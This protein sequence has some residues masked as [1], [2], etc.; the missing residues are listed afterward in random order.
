MV[1]AA[2]TGTRAGAGVRVGAA[3]AGGSG[4]A[5]AGDSA[6]ARA[7]AT[8]AAGPDTALAMLL[9]CLLTAQTSCLGASL[10]APEYTHPAAAGYRTLSFRHSPVL[11]ATCR[12]C[13]VCD[14]ASEDPGSLW[15]GT[16]AIWSTEGGCGSCCRCYDVTRA[17]T[18]T[19]ARLPSRPR[20]YPP[21]HPG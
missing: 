2:G 7:H 18:M 21:V 13:P 8:A 17:H 5:P 11:V 12:S 19:L 4:G 6:C 16:A 14:C 15:Q 20:I 10:P 3:V 9:G 1:V